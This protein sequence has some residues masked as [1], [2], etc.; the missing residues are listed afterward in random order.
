MTI[1]DVRDYLDGP[2]EEIEGWCDPYLWQAVI[3]LHAAQRALGA[4]GP[5]AE[6]GVHHGKLLIGLMKATGS[7]AGNL[8]IDLF[9]MQG[10]NLDKSGEGNLERLQ[11]NLAHCGYGADAV[12]FERA[13]SL[14]LGAIDLPRLRGEGHGGFAFVSVDGGH[15]VEHAMHDIRLAMELAMAP[16][17]IL[18]DDFFAPQWP[19][20]TEAIARLYLGDR[21]PF[22]PLLAG[23]NKLLLCHLSHR[24]HFWDALIGHIRDRLPPVDAK[25][26]MLFGHRT[27]AIQ[28]DR[29]LPPGYNGLPDDA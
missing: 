15:M 12:R 5:V 26:V 8:A 14:A 19:G 18:I 6:I 21:P 24:Q 13:D 22:V 1:K 16:G 27:I 3:P 2:F 11:A 23:Y 28:P 25:I 9:D 4:A 17:I 7:A 29:S 20:V 10:F